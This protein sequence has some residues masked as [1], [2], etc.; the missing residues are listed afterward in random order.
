MKLAARTYC[1]LLLSLWGAPAE[2]AVFDVAP[3]DVPGLIAAINAANS[4]GQD[5]TINIQGSYVLNSVDNATDGPNGLPSITST[6]I[7]DGGTGA[8]IIRSNSVGTPPFRIFHVSTSGLLTLDTVEVAGGFLGPGL[9]AREET[10]GGI[11]SIGHLRV[12]HSA[13]VSNVAE[14]DAGGIDQRAASSTF[15]M[16]DSIVSGNG[17]SAGQGVGGL[18]VCCQVSI[19]NSTIS[20]NFGTGLLISG[21]DQHGNID[22]AVQS[23]VV[24]SAIARNG[25]TGGVLASGRVVII[26]SSIVDNK[27][28]TGTQTGAGIFLHSGMLSLVNA[29]IANNTSESVDPFSTGGILADA[30]NNGRIELVN[31]ILT[32]NTRTGLP[33]DCGGAPITSL[34]NNII[35]STGGCAIAFLS[36]DQMGM[37]GLGPFTDNGDP[38]NGHYPLLATSPAI[39]H[40]SDEVCLGNPILATDQLGNARVGACDIGA[41]EHQPPSAPPVFAGVPGRPNCHGHSVA[42]LAR[43]F[44]GLGSAASGLGFRTVGELQTAIRAHCS[45]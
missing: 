28:G 17:V 33:S 43:R 7:I 39:D 15:I 22:A 36:T 45:E 18:G 20:D 30:V 9:V 4:N 14:D 29:T 37:A 24:N 41:V 8:R 23:E 44:G 6:I 3:G 31:T 26:N 35:G 12:L 19:N 1:S 2:A 40:G 16:R 11:F 34:G 42:A 13:I 32:G 27:G 21:L 5:D 25:G 38:G 10:G